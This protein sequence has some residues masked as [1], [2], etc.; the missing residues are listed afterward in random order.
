MYCEWNLRGKFEMLLIART[1]Q[2]T[3]THGYQF[4]F[5]CNCLAF[6]AIRV[7][8]SVFYR[9]VAFDLFVRVSA[10]RQRVTVQQQQ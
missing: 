10:G 8:E 5:L 3:L 7:C 9:V 4:E 2:A 6:H 1:L